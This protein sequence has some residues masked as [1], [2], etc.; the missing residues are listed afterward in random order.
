MGEGRPKRTEPPGLRDV[1]AVLQE[2]REELLHV[3]GVV[4]EEMIFPSP[5]GRSA[6]AVS[7]CF[8]GPP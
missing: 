6:A 5:H 4:P 8:A 2:R 1:E 7:A 3:Y